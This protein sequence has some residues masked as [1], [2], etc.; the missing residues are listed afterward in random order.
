[1]RMNSIGI[2]ILAALAASSTAAAQ[3]KQVRVALLSD[4]LPGVETSIAASLQGALE[5][6]GASR[7][8]Q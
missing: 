6:G 1:M 4:A 8:S 7:R 5:K 3:A 2:V